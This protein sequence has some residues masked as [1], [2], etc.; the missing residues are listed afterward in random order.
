MI[1]CDQILAVAGDRCACGRELG[2]VDT[3]EPG[4]LHLDV[5]PP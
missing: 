5:G 4:Q 1:E 3:G 2:D